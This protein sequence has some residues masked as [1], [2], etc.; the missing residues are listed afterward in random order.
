MR[1]KN[2][3]FT[4]IELVIVI[5]LLGILA[6]TVAPKFIDLS[7]DANRAKI[8]AMGGALLSANEIIFSKSVIKGVHNEEDMDAA[9]LNPN[10]AGARLMYGEMQAD[11]VTL[12]MFVEGLDDS[13]KWTLTP[14]G[15]MNMRI[16]PADHPTIGDGPGNC[17]V[18]YHHKHSWDDDNDPETPDAVVPTGITFWTDDC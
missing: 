1:N 6:A 8:E 16:H 12:K 3:G 17:F 10:Y 14:N 11:E 13:S 7:G 2:F 18:Q 15:D 9:V 5:V 4:L